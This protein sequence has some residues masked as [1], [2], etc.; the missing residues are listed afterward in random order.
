MSSLPG[1]VFMEESCEAMNSRLAAACRRYPGITTFNGTLHLFLGLGLPTDV[2][3]DSRDALRGG[4][5]EYMARRMLAVIANP[6]GLQLPAQTDSTHFHWVDGASS[7]WAAPG[8]LAR[9]L[10]PTAYVPIFQ[11]AADA[12]RTTGTRLRRHGLAG[13]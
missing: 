4:L 8:P 5:V 3:N 6:S 7:T 9:Q 11:R 10:D 2:P 1:C 13:R 12:H